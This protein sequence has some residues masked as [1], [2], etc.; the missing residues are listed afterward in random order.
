MKDTFKDVFEK[1]FTF[2]IEDYKHNMYE[3]YMDDVCPSRNKSKPIPKKVVSESKEVTNKAQTENSNDELVKEVK[4]LRKDI[5]N[6][7]AKSSDDGYSYYV[8]GLADSCQSKE[9]L[10]DKEER[11]KRT[12]GGRFR[13]SY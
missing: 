13:D 11:M 2:D 4:A 10:K 9:Y 1:A 12:G 5:A 8:P 3:E 7:T 6:L